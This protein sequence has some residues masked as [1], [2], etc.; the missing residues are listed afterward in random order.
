VQGARIAEAGQSIDLELPPALTI[1]SISTF[2]VDNT[3]STWDPANYYLDNTDPEQ[4]P[5]VCINLGAFWPT[6]LRGRDALKIVITA[7]FGTDFALPIAMK[8]AL[9]QMVSYYYNNRGD[10]D[11]AKAC[12]Y[13]MPFCMSDTMVRPEDGR[14]TGLNSQLQ[15]IPYGMR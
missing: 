8:T 9:K 15:D 5:R 3:E 6:N 11:E 10:C 2:D 14:P 12:S 1:E 7:G 13:C 4:I